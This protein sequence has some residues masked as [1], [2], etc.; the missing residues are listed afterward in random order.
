ML[1]P[2]YRGIKPLV[3][4]ADIYR[5]QEEDKWEVF[6]IISYKDVNSKI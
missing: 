2:A 3:Y 4:K 5:E 6:K 1:E